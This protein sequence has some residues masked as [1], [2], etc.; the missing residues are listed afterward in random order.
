[1]IYHKEFALVILWPPFEQDWEIASDRF[2]VF[3][4]YQS[5]VE[6]ELR[7]QLVDFVGITRGYR[8]NERDEVG[9]NLEV[10]I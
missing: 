8:A 7:A 2:E 9:L 6:A 3:E 1:M 4:A 5:H 10:H